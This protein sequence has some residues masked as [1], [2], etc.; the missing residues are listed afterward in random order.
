MTVC[1]GDVTG[2]PGPV[3]LSLSVLGRLV[4]ERPLLRRNARVGESVYVTGSLGGSGLGLTALQTGVPRAELVLSAIAAHRTPMPRLQEGAALA[5][6]SGVGACMDLSDGLAQ[7]AV[8]LAAASGVRL[9]LDLDLLPPHPGL[10]LLSAERA[11]HLMLY[12]GEDYELLFTGVGLP[13]CPATRI[14][15]VV[16]GAGIGWRRGETSTERR[17][18]GGFSHF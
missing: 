4:A 10:D 16:A 3:S 18:E 14:G 13:P 15:E 12:G 11:V 5:H 9:E 6:W 2:S 7:D 8:R 1:G 17:E